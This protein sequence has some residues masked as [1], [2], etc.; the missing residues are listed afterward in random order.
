VHL[1]F[2]LKSLR[3]K[4]CETFHYQQ[5]KTD[6]RKMGHG[7]IIRDK[8]LFIVGGTDGYLSGNVTNMS[9]PDQAESN[10]TSS[11]LCKS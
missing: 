2:W 9:L 8:Q 4:D 7:A 1:A 11:C 5:F 6:F 3:K 10:T